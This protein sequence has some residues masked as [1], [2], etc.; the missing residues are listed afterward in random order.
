[1]QIEDEAQRPDA[2][3][4][5]GDEGGQREQQRELADL[6]RLELE[7]RQLDPAARP[8]RGEAEREDGGDERD[9]AEVERPL[10]APEALDVDER[11]H[12]QRQRRP[13]PR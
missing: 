10:E 13:S 9:R 11:E 8:A 12:A 1:M 7:E 6:G 2:A 5:A 3:R 4:V